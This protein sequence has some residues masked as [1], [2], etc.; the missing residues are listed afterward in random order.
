MGADDTSR[1]TEQ[2]GSSLPRTHDTRAES[3][4]REREGRISNGRE[5]ECLRAR[6]RRLFDAD[7]TPSFMKQLSTRTCRLQDC[8]RGSAKRCDSRGTPL[9]GRES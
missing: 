3:P 2:G 1:A 8:W 9:G 7:T 4:E 6:S 5:S